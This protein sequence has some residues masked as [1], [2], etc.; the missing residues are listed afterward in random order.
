MVVLSNLPF[1]AAAVRTFQRFLWKDMPNARWP[2]DPT[3]GAHFYDEEA[4]QVLR[5]SSKSHWDIPL[6]IGERRI[7]FWVCHPTP[8]VFD[9]PEDRNGKRNHDEIRLLADYLSPKRSG[10]LRDDQGRSGGLPDGASFVIAGDLNADPWDGDSVEGA[11]AQ[12]LN[13]P[14]INRKQ[15]PSSRGAVED[16]QRQGL[17]NTTHRG[18]PAHD[19][20]DFSDR[21]SGNLRIDYVLPSSDLR[22]VDGGV[23]WPTADEPT[24]PLIA[25]SD[26]RLVWVD[27]QISP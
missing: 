26:H 24:R 9:G 4:R 8:P 14:R 7:H 1:D 10:Y 17:A 11:A 25:C 27:V 6:R 18:D 20:A 13:H 2:R 3:S 15:V 23:F 12:L 21:R 22:V 16:A 19:T 5:L